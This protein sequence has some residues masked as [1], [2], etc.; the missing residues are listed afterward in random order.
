ME[1][2]LEVIHVT[3]STT[4]FTSGIKLYYAATDYVGYRN[5]NE[6]SI[7]SRIPKYDLSSR[8]W[9]CWHESVSSSYSD[10]TTSSST[11]SYIIVSF[12]NVGGSVKPGAV[13]NFNYMLQD[14]EQTVTQLILPV[15]ITVRQCNKGPD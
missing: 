13:F 11:S 9:Y 6:V 14:Y 7:E 12:D 4:P 10:I 1:R 15:K 8:T 2:E 5:W 3:G